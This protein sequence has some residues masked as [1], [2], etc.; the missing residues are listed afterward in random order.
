MAP[1]NVKQ[2]LYGTS[3]KQ[4]LYLSLTIVTVTAKLEMSTLQQ[5]YQSG[6]SLIDDGP[7]IQMQRNFRVKD[8]TK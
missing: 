5:K 8:I 2:V 3:T 7:D 6:A 4:L 1:H